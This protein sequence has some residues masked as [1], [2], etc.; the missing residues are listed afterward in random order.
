M[1]QNGSAKHS[2]HNKLKTWAKNYQQNC[3]YTNYYYYELQLNKEC[4]L[5]SSLIGSIFVHYF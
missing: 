4:T 3:N 1:Q 2:K 5:L